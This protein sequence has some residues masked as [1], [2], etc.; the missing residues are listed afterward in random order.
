MTTVCPT[1]IFNGDTV[2]QIDGRCFVQVPKHG[3]ESIGFKPLGKFGR[4]NTFDQM[5]AGKLCVRKADVKRD[6]SGFPNDD[7]ISLDVCIHNLLYS[8]KFNV[9]Y[10]ASRNACSNDHIM[11]EIF[12]CFKEHK[13]SFIFQKDSYWMN[14]CSLHMDDSCS[15]NFDDC[16]ARYTRTLRNQIHYG[17]LSLESAE[18]FAEGPR[19]I[20]TCNTKGV[21]IMISVFTLI[22]VALLVIISCVVLNNRKLKAN[23]QKSREQPPAIE[24]EDSDNTQEEGND[25]VENA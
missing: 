6:F 14:L 21:N 23:K 17:Q 12:N 10:N 1:R 8:E 19:E 3:C 13:S 15:Y 2:F 24:T 25:D 18:R 9:P 11:D 16:Q 4:L 22:I 7:F 5:M 20:T